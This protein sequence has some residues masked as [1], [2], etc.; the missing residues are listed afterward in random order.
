MYEFQ[1]EHLRDLVDAHLQLIHYYQNRLFQERFAGDRNQYS[2]FLLCP[3]CDVTEH[4]CTNCSYTI[5]EGMNCVVYWTPKIASHL[6]EM[7]KEHLRIRIQTHQ[8]FVKE[9]VN[10][11]YE[12]QI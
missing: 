12:Q 10:K 2:E 9:L 6:S 8:R 11:I 7:N 1:I 4:E 3:L 5:I